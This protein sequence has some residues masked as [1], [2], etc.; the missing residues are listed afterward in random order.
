MSKKLG[1]IAVRIGTYSKDGQD[2]GRYETIGTLFQGDDGS[3]FGSIDAYYD[4]GKLHDLQRRDD[5]KR[6]REVRDS[7][8]VT[9]FTDRPD[10]SSAKPAAF[11]DLDA[12]F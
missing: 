2:K 5:H 11:D 9:I 1:D 8:S 6:G 12:P 4:L 3:Y 7:L 10:G